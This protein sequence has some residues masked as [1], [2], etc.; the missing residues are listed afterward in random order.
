VRNLAHNIE[1]WKI[2][3]RL[4]LYL[5]G[6]DSPKSRRNSS[7]LGEGG[8][9]SKGYR[10]ACAR[11]MLSRDSAIPTTHYG[12]GANV[13]SLLYPDLNS[14]ERAVDCHC[15]VPITLKP[16]DFFKHMLV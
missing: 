12:C 4:G 11:R 13:I 16:L 3:A 2:A 10:A 15:P 8:R 6:A 1:F 9:L 7:A 5:V 14:F